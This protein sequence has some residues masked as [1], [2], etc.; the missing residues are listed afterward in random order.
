MISITDLPPTTVLQ[1]ECKPCFSLD[2][3]LFSYNISAFLCLVNLR[4]IKPLLIYPGCDFVCSSKLS[5][6]NHY[7]CVQ[8]CNLLICNRNCNRQCYLLMFTLTVFTLYVLKHF[9]TPKLNDSM[10]SLSLTS[11][12]S[13]FSLVNL[14]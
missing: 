10:T 13:P 14:S 5:S 2:P 4:K 6:L 12:F 8:C 3:S 11:H 1:P 9:P 7:Y